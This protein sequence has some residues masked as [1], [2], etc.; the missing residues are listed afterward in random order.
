M[1]NFVVIIQLS[2]PLYSI[3]LWDY[4]LKSIFLFSIHWAF[5][6][7]SFFYKQCC[8]EY[9]GVLVHMSKVS[10]TRS[11]GGYISRRYTK[12][13]VST[14]YVYIFSQIGTNV[15]LGQCQ[16]FA[17]MWSNWNS[18][19]VLGGVWDSIT[20][21]NGRGSVKINTL[22]YKYYANIILLP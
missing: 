22:I 16:G 21:K 3:P 2:S 20:I 12:D 1:L 15:K 10:W 19:I 17:R 5:W 4:I 18:F 8:C 13:G 14:L 7:F 9:S 6:W 11:K